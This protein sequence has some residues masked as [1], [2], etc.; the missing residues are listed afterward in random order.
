MHHFFFLASC[1]FG[2]L[3]SLECSAQSRTRVQELKDLSTSRA[4]DMSKEDDTDQLATEPESK[5]TTKQPREK[6]TRRRYSGYK[7]A[8]GLGFSLSVILAVLYLMGWTKAIPWGFGGYNE[9]NKVGTGNSG[10]VVNSRF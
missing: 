5:E 1:E 4:I 7:M 3:K 9:E 6:S 10:L 2:S 8:A